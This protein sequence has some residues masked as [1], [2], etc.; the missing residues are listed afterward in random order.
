[1]GRNW[2]D[3]QEIELE[4]KWCILRT[5]PR[6][7]ITLARTLAE[8][9]IT[10]WTPTQIILRAKTRR[11]ASVERPA[12]ILPS[13]V[14]AAAHEA[15]RLSLLRTLPGSRHVGFSLFRY[16]GRVPLIDDATLE[17]LRNQERSAADR[18]EA[19]KRR[20]QIPP[21]FQAGQR[22]RVEKSA[23]SGLEGVVQSQAGE[24]AM[25]CFGGRQSFKISS[26]ILQADESYIAQPVVDVA[27]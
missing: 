4:G 12:P 18:Y 7:T 8:D 6:S 1:M 14:F 2:N 5:A 22:V 10:V 24:Y 19:A 11:K 21:A 3:G 9:G 16:A 17:Q 15:A 27:A 20:V 26:W 13:F 23:W 25:I